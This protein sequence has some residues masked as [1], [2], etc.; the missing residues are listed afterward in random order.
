MT[1]EDEDEYT[2]EDAA[3]DLFE[4]A[5]ER[6]EQANNLHSQLNQMREWSTDEAG[7]LAGRAQ[8][9]HDL[10]VLADEQLEEVM[11]QARQVRTVFQRIS[12]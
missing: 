6:V 10:G 11:A 12:G 1:E 3:D 4:Q 8:T 7:E 9:L 2:L 5:E